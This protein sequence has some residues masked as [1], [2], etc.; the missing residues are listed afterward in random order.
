MQL[1][2]VKVAV[3]LSE[4]Y[5][6]HGLELTYTVEPNEQVDFNSLFHSV[7]GEIEAHLAER[8]MLKKLK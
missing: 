3:R 7:E 6:S 4:D 2:E 5:N 1:K 8:K